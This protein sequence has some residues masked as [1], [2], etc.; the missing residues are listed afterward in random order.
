[1]NGIRQNESTLK[2]VIFGFKRA[3]RF[4]NVIS[5]MQSAHTKIAGRA[6]F[7]P[8]GTLAPE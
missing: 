6:F 5:L 3:S 8:F 7:A 2:P 4:P 1:M